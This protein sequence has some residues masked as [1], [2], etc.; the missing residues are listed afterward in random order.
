MLT[1]ERQ[2]ETAERIGRQNSQG[3]RTATTP[4]TEQQAERMTRKRAMLRKIKVDDKKSGHFCGAS[5]ER[6]R[7][8]SHKERL[9]VKIRGGIGRGSRVSPVPLPDKGRQRSRRGSP[10]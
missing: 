8:E 9:T 5:V 1:A 7:N 4:P 2:G 3:V 6:K 10:P